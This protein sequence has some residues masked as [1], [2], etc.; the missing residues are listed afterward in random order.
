MVST[1]P[2]SKEFIINSNLPSE[3]YWPKFWIASHNRLIWNN[4][5]YFI[6]IKIK[7]EELS[8]FLTQLPFQL[9]VVNPP[10]LAFLSV[11][12][13]TKD[14]SNLSHFSW[15]VFA[16]SSKSKAL[17]TKCNFVHFNN[18]SCILETTS[19]ISESVCKIPLSHF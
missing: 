8:I 4:I 9:L 7:K 15:K 10:N 18:I 17:Y 5:I 16:L 1:A 11:S 12:T 3:K 14:I 13:Q 2:L 19:Y 6:I